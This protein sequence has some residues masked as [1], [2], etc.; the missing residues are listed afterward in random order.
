MKELRPEAIKIVGA[1]RGRTYENCIIDFA[2]ATAVIECQF[3]ACHCVRWKTPLTMVAGFRDCSWDTGCSFEGDAWPPP[4]FA[5]QM[6]QVK[7]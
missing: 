2:Q 3:V 6:D 4:A 5:S 1:V 7:H